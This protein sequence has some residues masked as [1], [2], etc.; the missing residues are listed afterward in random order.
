VEENTVAQKLNLL[1]GNYQRFGRVDGDRML[2]DVSVH[3]DRVIAPAH[4]G[5]AADG[6]DDTYAGM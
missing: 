5:S 3:P 4:A 1:R 6:R 2:L